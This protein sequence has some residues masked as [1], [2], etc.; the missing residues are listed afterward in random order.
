MKPVL[1]EAEQLRE[2]IKTYL[3][4]GAETID[5]LITLQKDTHGDVQ[6]L[7]ERDLEDVEQAQQASV[8]QLVN[9]FG[10][11]SNRLRSFAI[12]LCRDLLGDRDSNSDYEPSD[13][14]DEQREDALKSCPACK[15]G[16]MFVIDSWERGER[17]IP[18]TSLHRGLHLAL[19]ML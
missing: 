11:L 19:H 15:T 6:S 7:D 4:V 1:V 10:I 17:G 18:E 9:D 8:V 13:A 5:G 16:Q 12:E 14:V 2:L 3:G